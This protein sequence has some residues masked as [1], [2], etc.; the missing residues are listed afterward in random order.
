MTHEDGT[1]IELDRRR[2]SDRAR[3]RRRVLGDERFVGFEFESQSA[4]E[5]AR[6]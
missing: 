2:P 1:E 5:Y 6:E 4:E 3:S